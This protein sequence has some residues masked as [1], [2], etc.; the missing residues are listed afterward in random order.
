M[1]QGSDWL[2][3]LSS[4][5]HKIQIRGKGV[6]QRQ[7]SSYGEVMVD[8][9][10]VVTLWRKYYWLLMIAREQRVIGVHEMLKD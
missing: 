1:S 8:S 3:Y 5:A 9:K 6:K 10:G 4:G 7:H 2:A